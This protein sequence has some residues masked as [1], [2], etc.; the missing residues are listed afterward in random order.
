MTQQ[1]DDCRD[2]ACRFVTWL[3]DNPNKT[4]STYSANPAGVLWTKIW[5]F[6]GSNFWTITTAPGLYDRWTIQ[7]SDQV[8]KSIQ[9]ALA[10]EK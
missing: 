8:S 2:E 7:Q 5:K 6:D 1:F 4:K 9:E 10:A 3:I